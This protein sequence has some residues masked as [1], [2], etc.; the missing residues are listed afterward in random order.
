MVALF[1]QNYDKYF[2]YPNTLPV[3]CLQSMYG[4]VIY[5]SRR[6]NSA[7]V[8]AVAMATF[9]DSTVGDPGG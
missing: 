9:S 4:Y 7:S 1:V 6:R 3:R 5:E 8:M 2:T